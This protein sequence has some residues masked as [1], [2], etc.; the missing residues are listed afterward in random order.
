MDGL[1]GWTQRSPPL[2]S[3]SSSVPTAA[4]ST[5]TFPPAAAP[6]RSV[7]DDVRTI[8]LIGLAHGTSH[9]FHLLLPPLVPWFIAESGFT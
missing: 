1:C 6:T 8:G 7:R 5:S 3:R 9:F 2:G 4:F